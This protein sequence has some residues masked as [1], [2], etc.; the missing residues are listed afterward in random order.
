MTG[1]FDKLA[2]LGFVLVFLLFFIWVVTVAPPETVVEERRASYSVPTVTLDGIADGSFVARLEEYLTDAIPCRSFFYRLHTV[3]FSELFRNPESHGV[4][5]C[6]NGLEKV[7]PAFDENLILHNLAVVSEYRTRLSQNSRAYSV[8]IPDKSVYTQNAADYKRA[9]ALLSAQGDFALIECRDTLTVDDYF[10]GDIHIRPEC[11]GA[12]AERLSGKMGFRQ[13][14][15]LSVSEGITA[16]GTL[17]LQYPLDLTD[18]FS[19]LEAS[20]S[21]FDGL[22]ITTPGGESRALY[23]DGAALTDPYDLYLGGEAGNGILI[24]KNEAADENRRLIVFRDS[25]ARAF[26]PYLAADYGEIV[27][28]D[29]RAPR[30][31]ILSVLSTYQTLDCD[32][33]LFIS[34]HTLFTTRF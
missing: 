20:D 5:R 21:F 15:A 17:A 10:Y 13:T 28:V 19:R 9:L 16:R 11:Y 27:L 22:S 8:L 31:A 1:L 30:H 24:L 25:F 29:L 2:A 26:V 33:L 6:G 14:A 3:V 32:I 12:L 4:R 23:S 7:L 34:T 18:S